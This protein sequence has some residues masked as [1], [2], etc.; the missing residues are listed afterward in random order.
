MSRSQAMINLTGAVI[1]GLRFQVSRA[2]ISSLVPQ[3]SL[4]LIAVDTAR[5]EFN[6]AA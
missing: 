1:N 2:K 5:A 4:D 3:Q 6:A